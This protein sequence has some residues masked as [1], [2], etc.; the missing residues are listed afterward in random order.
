MELH[1]TTP[2]VDEGFPFIAGE[3]ILHFIDSDPAGLPLPP[4]LI[5]SN[6]LNPRLHLK[7]PPARCHPSQA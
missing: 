1:D 5:S 3:C 2:K 7:V 4:L 6:Q